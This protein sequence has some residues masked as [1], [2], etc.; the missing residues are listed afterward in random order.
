MSDNSYRRQQRGVTLV[1]LL[2]VLAIGAIIAAAMASLFAQSSSTREQVNRTSQRIENGRYALDAIAEDIRLAG[3][4]GDLWASG[5]VFYKYET[6]V[7]PCVTTLSDIQAP[8]LWINDSIALTAATNSGKISANERAVIDYRLAP[9]APLPPAIPPPPT[10]AYPFAVVPAPLLG[11]EGHGATYTLPTGCSATL[12]NLKSGTDILVIR[13]AST[14]ATPASALSGTSAAALQVSTQVSSGPT[15]CATEAGLLIDSN[16]S[17]LTLHRAHPS[18]T[19]DALVRPLIVRVYYIATCNICS[20]AN[21]DT[22]PTLKMAEL[23]NGAF[24]IRPIAPGIDHLHLEYGL[25]VDADG[26]VDEYRLST[27]DTKVDTRDW[28][29]VLAVRAYVLS[30]DLEGTPSHTDSQS[31]TLGSKTI[32]AYGDDI[33]RNTSSTTIRLLNIAASREG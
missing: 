12:S 7:N 25:D 17:N 2:I 6:Q 33:K 18:C 26:S 21:A 23:V 30:R 27:N 29:D 31:Y 16:P 13:R 9:P 22:I 24:A 11:Y 5:G 20:G 8:W 4:Y 14:A 32:A 3:Y 28:S 10:L 15:S 1:E 19:Q